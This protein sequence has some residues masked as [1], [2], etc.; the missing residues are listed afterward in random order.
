MDVEGAFVVGSAVS[1]RSGG[2]AMTVTCI[3]PGPLERGEAG[4]GC[5][6]FDANLRKRS[7]WFVAVTLK[8]VGTDPRP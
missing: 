2:P 8:R 1:L 5:V 3:E 4:I 6:W 7:A